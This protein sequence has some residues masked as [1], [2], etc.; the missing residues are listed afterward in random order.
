[1]ATVDLDLVRKNLALMALT[2]LTSDELEEEAFNALHDCLEMFGMEDIC[3]A[4]EGTDN[5]FYL[6]DSK[7]ADFEKA[8]GVS[9]MVKPTRR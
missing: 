2:I 9:V 1:M 6:K 8:Y 4:C 7:L 3:T 5:W